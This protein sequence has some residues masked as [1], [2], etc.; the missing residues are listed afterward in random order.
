LYQE[1]TLSYCDPFYDPSMRRWELQHYGFQCK[2]IACTDIEVPGS[3]AEKSRERR[4]R[5]REL[6]DSFDVQPSKD[7]KLRMGVEMAKLM[8]EE[9]LC[10]PNLAHTCVSSIALGIVDGADG[11]QIPSDCKDLGG[12]ERFQN[13]CSRGDVGS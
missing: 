10:T 11:R 7:Q 4:W 5:L 12:Q 6:D 2:C 13:G 1:I 8:R 9:G 3:F